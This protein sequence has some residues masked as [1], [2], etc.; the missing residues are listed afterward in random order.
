[1]QF[2][3]M[4]LILQAVLWFLLRCITE[5]D[6]KIYYWNLCKYIDYLIGLFVHHKQTIVTELVYLIINET[7]WRPGFKKPLAPPFP[8]KDV[9]MLFKPAFHSLGV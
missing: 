1:M 9:L 6:K 5:K 8:L 3:K 4:T 7:K 2:I